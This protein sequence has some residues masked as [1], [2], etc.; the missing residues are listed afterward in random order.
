M[1]VVC[2]E[3]PRTLTD[4]NGIS[5]EVPEIMIGFDFMGFSYE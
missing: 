5:M 2:T 3:A 4:N 1:D